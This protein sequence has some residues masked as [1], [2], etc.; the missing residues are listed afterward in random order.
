MSRKTA[1]KVTSAPWLTP[2][3]LLH[4]LRLERE[5]VQKQYQGPVSW[6]AMNMLKLHPQTILQ[7]KRGSA[8]GH[9]RENDDDVRR[10]FP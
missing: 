5:R 1:H 7:R 3:L 8:R 6:E 2:K 10:I 9:A 4:S